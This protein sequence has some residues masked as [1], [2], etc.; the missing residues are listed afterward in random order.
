MIRGVF[1]LFFLSEPRRYE[2]FESAVSMSA[3]AYRQQKTWPRGEEPSSVLLRHVSSRTFDCHLPG[4]NPAVIVILVITAHLNYRSRALGVQAGGKSGQRCTADS[5]GAEKAVGLSQVPESWVAA[6]APCFQRPLL[7]CWDNEDLGGRTYTV[8][9]FQSFNASISQTQF[10][11]YLQRLPFDITSLSSI[12]LQ[13]R[14]C[15]GGKGAIFA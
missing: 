2:I 13:R 3:R 7:V 5:L 14:R 11:T 12:E 6:Q 9:S 4:I 1:Q 10:L 8:G 15:D